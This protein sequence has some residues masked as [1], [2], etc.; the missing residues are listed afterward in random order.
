LRGRNKPAIGV[1]GTP[2]ASNFRPV[3]ARQTSPSVWRRVL[4]VLLV[5]VLLV[6]SVAAQAL[7]LTPVAILLLVAAVVALA[8]L[9]N[10][11]TGA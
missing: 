1:F 7:N 10:P 11:V 6:G 4:L 3:A 2:M 8:P 9:V 5:A